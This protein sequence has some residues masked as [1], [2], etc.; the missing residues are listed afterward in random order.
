MKKIIKNT[1]SLV[2]LSGLAIMGI[3]CTKNDTGGK[4]L[5]HALIYYK[6]TPF[7]NA[8]VYVKFDAASAPA[9]PS[10]DY[11]FIAYGEGTDNH[12]HIDNLR[13]GKYYLYATAANAVTG[14]TLKGG[15]AVEIKWKDRKETLEP[16][17]ELSE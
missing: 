6:G 12:V 1:L 8:T 16:V 10:I 15:R 5:V 2:L 11:D 14:S 9:D 3:S 7:N 4:A 17:I 13:P